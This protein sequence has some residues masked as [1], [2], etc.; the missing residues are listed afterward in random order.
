MKVRTSLKKKFFPVSGR[1]IFFQGAPVSTLTMFFR[2]GQ[3]LLN[4]KYDFNVIFF[5]FNA[6]YFLHSS[7]NVHVNISSHLKGRLLCFSVSFSMPQMTA[8]TLQ[9]WL[10]KGYRKVFYKFEK[11]IVNCG[12]SGP[13]VLFRKGVLKICSKF[14]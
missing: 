5:R 12:S 6:L 14:T 13:E 1:V 4:V 10:L 8:C 9:K 2:L 3:L 7:N 11:S